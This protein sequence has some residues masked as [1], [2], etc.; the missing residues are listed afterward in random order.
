MK[1][2]A[3]LKILSE[4]QTTV[5]FTKKDGSRRE[6]NCTRSPSLIPSEFHPKNTESEE[7]GDNIRVFDLDK[8]AWR[9]FNYNS[10]IES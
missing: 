6:M 4:N 10:L 3:L 9:S 5:V 7:I 2:E 1:K 8:S